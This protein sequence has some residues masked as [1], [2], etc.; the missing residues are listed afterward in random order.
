MKVILIGNG[1]MGRA[2]VDLA[3]KR[4]HE[5]IAVY[6]VE[7]ADKL[8]K[9]NLSKA[10][11]VFEFTNPES[12]F[13]NITKCLDADVACVSGTTGWTDKLEQIVQKCYKEGKTFF[14]A[15]NF[16]I[17][18]NI[19]YEL[20]KKLADIMNKYQNYDVKIAETHHIHKLDAPS[21]TA[22]EIANQIINNLERKNRWIANKQELGA[23]SVSSFREGEVPGIHTV[24]YYS[25][26]DSLSVTHSA[27]NRNGLATGAVIAAEFIEG[28]KGFFSMADIFNN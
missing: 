9:E 22:I 6:D 4:G 13:D 10:D 24:T 15:S 3:Q 7:D 12:A 20:N 16:S 11:V 19:L 23:I 17:G 8:T 27:N 21:G 5:L 14:Y 25:D 18:V 1:K 26:D 2:V 28:K